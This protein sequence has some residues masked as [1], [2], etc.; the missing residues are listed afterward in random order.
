MCP[1]T[2]SLSVGAALALHRGGKAKF[3]T[4][5]EDEASTFF[6]FFFFFLSLGKLTIFTVVNVRGKNILVRKQKLL[7][8][9][10]SFPLG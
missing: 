2:T 7:L 3:Y 1:S 9:D 6:I 5:K 8:C 10:F 4:K